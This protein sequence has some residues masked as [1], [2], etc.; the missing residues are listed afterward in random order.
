MADVANTLNQIM[1]AKRSG[2]KE[3]ILPA[4]KFLIEVLKIM[5]ENNYLDYNLNEDKSKVI[6][7]IKEINKC[8]AIKPRFNV[9]QEKMEQY[10]KR[11]L[12]A[13]DI[14][15]L[16]I[17]TSKGLMTHKEAMEKGAGGSLIAYCF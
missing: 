3:C 8:K 5:K 10:I 13:R 11:F 16:I 12:P 14:G 6:V 2:K 1:N 17:S 9:K 15:I 4:S 7:G